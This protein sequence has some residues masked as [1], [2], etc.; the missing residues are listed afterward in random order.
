MY[1]N[2]IVAIVLPL[3]CRLLDFLS[4]ADQMTNLYTE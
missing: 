4:E 3:P 2:Q 1:V